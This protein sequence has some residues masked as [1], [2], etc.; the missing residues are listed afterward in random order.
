MR[1]DQLAGW[2]PIRLYW[3]QSSAFMDWCH[4]GERRFT[5]PFFDQTVERCLSH[6]FNL[7]FRHQTPIDVV[8]W[9]HEESPGLRP[10]GFIFHLSRCGSTLISQMLAA[11]PQN[12]VISEASP[13]DSVLRAR[14][15]NPGV[16]DEMRAAWLQWVISALGQRWSGDEKYL[17]IKF[18]SWSA[19]DLRII[20]RAFPGVPWIFVYRDPVEVLVSQLKRRGAHMVPG[21]MEPEFLGVDRLSILHMQPEEFCARVLAGVCDAALRHQERGEAM[22]VNYR[23]LPDAVWSSLLDFFRVEYTAAD[24]EIMRR[25]SQ[26]NAKNP[27][28]RFE[29]DTASKNREASDEL[30]AVVNKWVMPLY[31]RL[32]ATRLAL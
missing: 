6:P 14:F 20:K 12:V 2:A 5:D 22:L 21:M 7:L 13:I 28:L 26:F 3:Q 32:E 29:N 30:R 23:Q 11:L 31:E 4:L 15:H 25:T 18:D 1:A 19:I 9:W 17:F 27:S 24:V 16:T 10:T 8:G